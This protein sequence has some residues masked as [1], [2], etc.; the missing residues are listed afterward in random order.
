MVA[1]QRIDGP[2]VIK[3]T[4]HGVLK[5]GDVEIPCFVLE[6]G[7]R[8]LSTRGVLRALGIQRGTRGNQAGDELADFL[9][10]KAVSPFVSREMLPAMNSRIVFENPVGGGVVHGHD[11]AIL[12]FICWVLHDAHVAGALRSTQVAMAR[13][14]NVVLRA[15]THTTV[16]ALV[17][18]ATGYQSTRA[19]DALRQLFASHLGPLRPWHKTFPDSYYRHIYRLKGWAYDASDTRRPPLVGKYTRNI[20]YRRLLPELCDEL[21]I[22]NPADEN[23]RRSLK[24]HQLLTEKIGLPALQGHIF[25]VEFVAERHRLWDPFKREV[26]QRWPIHPQMSFQLDDD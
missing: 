8:V 13:T 22:R 1:V 9:A 15:L 3:A 19:S 25:K 11:S 24:H 18:E 20:V 10:G 12:G 7:Q 21:E 16:A 4:H 14:A 2:T 6:D 26:E 23:G 5:I 17:D